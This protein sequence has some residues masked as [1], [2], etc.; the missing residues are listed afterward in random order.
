MKTFAHRVEL[1]GVFFRLLSTERKAFSSKTDVLPLSAWDSDGQREIL[2]GIA[3]LSDYLDEAIDTTAQEICV[4]HEAVAAFSDADGASLGLPPTMPYQLRVWGEGNWF[5]NSYT[6]CSEVLDLGAPVYIDKRVGAFIYIGSKCY[7]IPSPLY[8]V[9][10]L[11]SRFPEG[12]DEKIEAQ[13]TLG[14]LL[15]DPEL[16][17]SQ[18]NVDKPIANIRIQHVA[19]F[20]ASVVGNTVDPKFYPILFGQHIVNEAEDTG[21]LLSETQQ[22]LNPGQRDA[23]NA[24]FFSAPQAKATYVLASG[25][26]V[27]IDPSIRP[28][29]KAFRKVCASS[30]DVRRAFL[31][32]PNAVLAENLDEPNDSPELTI[33]AG[34][35][36]TSQFSERV[37]GVGIWSA[38]DLPWLASESNNWGTEVLVFTQAGLAQP[39]VIAKSALPEA[40]AKVESGLQSQASVVTVGDAEIPVST[41]LVNSMRQMLPVSADEEET[42]DRAKVEKPADPRLSK[43]VVETLDGY[44]AINFVRN[45]TPPPR[46]LSV[47]LPR[48][49]VPSTKPM[50]HQMAGLSWLVKA[51][52]EGVPGLL[53]ADDMGLGKTLQALLLM[54]CYREQSAEGKTLPI[55]VVAPTGLLANWLQEI[56]TH[57]GG[58]GIG[59][60]TQA[61]GRFLKPLKVSGATNDM[62]SGLPTLNAAALESADIVLTTYESL[63][64]YQISFAGIRFGI[65]IYDE[66][67]KVKNPRS[68]ISRAAAAVNAGF[69]IGLTGTPVENS[70]ADLWTIFDVLS[71]GLMSRSLKDFMA[72][73]GGSPDDPVIQERLERLHDELVG[74]AD[75]Q[76][77]TVLRRMK[78]E[79]FGEKSMPKKIVVPVEKTS[80]EMPKEQ[81]DAYHSL[82]KRVQKNEIR[83]IEGLQGFK[84]LSMAP[85]EYEHFTQDVQG[86][87]RSSGRLHQFFD[88]LDRIKDEN[89][90][91]L[92]FIESLKLQPILSQVIKER[93]KLS[94][95]P[96]IINGAI[97]GASRQKIVN[98]F[99]KEG[100]G[101]NV[102]LISPKAGGVGL[103]LT[104]ANHVIHLERWWNPA[105]EDQCNDRAYRIG[106]T[107][108]VVVYMPATYHPVREIPSF[109]MVLH[110]I[111][112]K[113]RH[114]AQSIFFPTELTPEEFSEIFRMGSDPIEQVTYQPLTLE[115]TWQLD[116]GEAFETYVA[117][118]LRH[119]GFEIRMT[120]KSWDYGCDLV[121][122]K[123]DRI[124]LCQIKQVRSDKALGSGV[125][126]ILNAKGR[127]KSQV[128]SDLALITNARTVTKSQ[129]S[130]ASEHSIK[131][132]LGNSVQDYG[133]AL[134]ASLM[135]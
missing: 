60:V 10:S 1:E 19:K 113:K 62:A 92:I 54:A 77:A 132:I 57:F 87:I 28:A 27:Y 12:R 90:K 6:L 63:R 52:N 121:A 43:Y 5:D 45:R 70:I 106:Q 25:E 134:I 78:T 130:L 18:V 88:I 48:V 86:F 53:I 17:S 80:I 67:Q 99:Q 109:D 39:I 125:N 35:V 74:A 14:R 97:E 71:P 100:D 58:Q 4:P 115:E 36:E 116:S 96:L 128:P 56:D 30:T 22:I 24:E 55:L 118:A 98:S 101:F 15:G 73:F 31:K 37:T 21:E 89:E 32:A 107:K 9:V 127:Y 91:V 76:T 65:V 47:R 93:Y 46:P 114:L 51:Y 81:A 112:E 84:R 79:V 75:S 61:Y 123:G 29:L 95:R 2:V 111:L 117:A 131:I 41:E 135:H 20:S 126:E 85:R 64:D 103:T 49:L 83:M 40:I 102:I 38:P 44:E 59:S 108:D 50:A 104:A 119:A 105:V 33:D 133:A 94:Q 16:S 69:S 13:S 11:V 72:E 26:Y 66:I 3:S 68:L 7:R 82:L 34:F 120:K 124:I 129:K 110:Q 42:K 8:E 23:F 122:K